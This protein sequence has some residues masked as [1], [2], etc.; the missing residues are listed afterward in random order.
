[1][2][3]V[4]WTPILNVPRRTFPGFGRNGVGEFVDQRVRG[5]VAQDRPANGHARRGMESGHGIQI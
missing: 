3:G 2:A 1:M 4:L 5:G